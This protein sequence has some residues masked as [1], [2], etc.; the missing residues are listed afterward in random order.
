M[1][2]KS[3]TH[4]SVEVMATLELTAVF[5]QLIVADGAGILTGGLA[6]KGMLL[7]KNHQ[8]LTSTFTQLTRSLTFNQ[9]CW[10]FC[11]QNKQSIF[12]SQ[13]Y[14]ISCTKHMA[15]T[16]SKQRKT[17][18][19]VLLFPFGFGNSSSI[20]P[21]LQVWLRGVFAGG[22]FRGGCCP[23]GAGGDSFCRRFPA[24]RCC[25]GWGSRARGRHGSACWRCCLHRDHKGMVFP[26]AVL[27]QP[28]VEKRSSCSPGTLCCW[29][30]MSSVTRLRI[31]SGLRSAT[32]FPVLLCTSMMKAR[33]SKLL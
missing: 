31:S 24:P 18:T 12:F 9:V 33:R 3:R 27:L 21:G 19:T 5:A 15:T 25:W 28:H 30:R 22:G 17:Y 26:G 8:Q 10:S 11:T 7:F 14:F 13:D 6:R 20:A 2:N 32:V 16:P 23:G 29:S 1:R 4:L